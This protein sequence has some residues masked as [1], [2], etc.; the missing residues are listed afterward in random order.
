M[1]VFK[2]GARDRILHSGVVSIKSDNVAYAHILEFLKHC[3]AVERFSCAASVLTAAVKHGHDDRDASRLARACAD[4]A[5]QVF[6][7]LVGS[8]G[9]FLPEERIRYAVIAGVADDIQIFAAHSLV[10][11]ALCVA[12]GETGAIRFENERIFVKF[13]SE[14]RLAE[15][16]DKSLVDKLRK[17]FRTGCRDNGDRCARR[18]S[19]N[20]KIRCHL[21]S[22]KLVFRVYQTI[23]FLTI[24]IANNKINFIFLSFFDGNFLIPLRIIFDELRFFMQTYTLVKYFNQNRVHHRNAVAR[25]THFPVL[26]FKENRKSVIDFA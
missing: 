1:H 2:A 19:E 8:D 3:C 22:P 9:Y 13:L 20:R 14:M 7:M 21:C 26:L 17:F 25:Q 6:K 23:S 10:D 12:V 4:D 18:L 24:N 15:K 16:S 11:Y 5:F